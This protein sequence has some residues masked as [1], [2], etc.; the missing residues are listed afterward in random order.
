MWAGPNA[1]VGAAT[2]DERGK[3]CRM[4]RLVAFAVLVLV[5]AATLLASAGIAAAH[6]RCAARAHQGE[7][8]VVANGQTEE[9]PAWHGIS[10]ATGR[11]PEG[12]G[13]Q[14]C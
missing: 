7:G 12:Y 10:N 14:R 5:M 2:F 4:R 3:G 9:D 13:V 11:A 6:P 8:Q 1:R